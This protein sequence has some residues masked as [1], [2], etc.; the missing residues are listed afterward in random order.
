MTGA[1]SLSVPMT[2]AVY[3]A[4]WLDALLAEARVIDATLSLLDDPH[5]ADALNDV[6]NGR[7]VS[8]HAAFKDLL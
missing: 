3:M 6:R 1:L 7:L 4:C 8:F 5:L 2:T